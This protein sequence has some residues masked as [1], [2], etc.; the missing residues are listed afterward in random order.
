MKQQRSFSVLHIV[1]LR[2]KN[3]YRSKN[4]YLLYCVPTAGYRISV[5]PDAIRS[6]FGEMLGPCD[7]H[8]INIERCWILAALFIQTPFAIHWQAWKKTWLVSF[9]LYPLLCIRFYYPIHE[10]N[11]V[12][13]T[14]TSDPPLTYIVA[15]RCTWLC[16]VDEGRL[17]STHL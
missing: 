13:V 12:S 15:E 16:Y 8:L 2:K 6:G 4:N 9:Q 1:F 10:N 17:I 14:H 5:I 11:F 7:L 3:M